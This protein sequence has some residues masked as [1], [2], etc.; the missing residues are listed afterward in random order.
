MTRLILASGSGARRALLQNAG[1]EFDVVPS[2]VDERALEA[3]LLARGASPSEIAAMLAAGKAMD[4]SRRNP[5]AFV[6]GAD[7]TL[8]LDGHRGTKSETKAEA[9]AQLARLA[10]RT[11]HLRSAVAV[12]RN[13]DI[14]WSDLDSAA[15]TMRQLSDAEIDAYIA[16]IDDGVLKS[17]GVY[18]LEGEGVRLFDRIEGSYFTI[19][20]LPLLPLLAYLRS[21]GAIV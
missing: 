17:V 18:R 20:G 14:A 3:P 1:L 5:E 15:L 19:L 7:Q 6:I 16:R 4:V 21:A 12:A 13:G 10:G 9:R 8:D 2:T 11:H